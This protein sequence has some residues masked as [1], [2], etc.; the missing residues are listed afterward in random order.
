MSLSN[1]PSYHAFAAGV[2]VL[3]WMQ[4]SHPAR[5]GTP[6]APPS[7]RAAMDAL[8]RRYQR[9][10]RQSGVT[11]FEQLA[12]DRAWVSR[13]MAA[14]GVATARILR[15]DF[16]LQNLREV[17]EGIDDCVIK[18][19]QAHSSRGVLSLQRL[20]E[21]TFNCL[22]Q[23][24]AMRLVEILEYLYAEM[25]EHQFPNHWQLEELLLPPS[26][27][28]RPVDD[29]KFYAFRGRTALVLQVARSRQGQRYRW[30]DRDWCPVDTGK[31]D[32]ALDPTLL[33]PRNPQVLLATA[34]RVSASLPVPFCRIDLYETH[35]GV[36]LGELTAVP[37]TY[38]A[39]GD[40]ADAYLG[41][42]FELA[43]S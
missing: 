18:P 20:D 5:K 10:A 19:K 15:E 37:G 1:I 34:E 17:L 12:V 26:G 27:L 24:R 4:A 8:V 3:E 40:Q 6:P 16:A 25:R 29:F 22:Q 30:Y 33:S 36:V 31:Y 28:L 9:E 35:Q 41:A 42:M 14:Q 38:H 7:F 39:F 32:G 21:I 43:G 13:Q 23:R 2:E 11:S